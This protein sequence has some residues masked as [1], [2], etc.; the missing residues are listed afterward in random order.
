[1]ELKIAAMLGSYFVRHGAS[2]SIGRGVLVVGYRTTVVEFH[3]DDRG[4]FTHATE[5]V[6]GLRFTTIKDATDALGLKLEQAA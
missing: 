5:D 2:I 6:M 3:F 1:M 4:R